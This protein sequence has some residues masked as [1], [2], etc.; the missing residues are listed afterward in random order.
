[1]T[2]P[3]G[4]P[5]V[6]VVKISVV[7]IG[8]NG[9]FVKDDSRQ[10]TTQQ[11][12]GPG[13]QIPRRAL[14]PD[15]EQDGIGKGDQ[16]GD[17][18]RRKHRRGI[19]NYPGEMSSRPPE[20]LLNSFSAYQTRGICRRL[21]YHRHMKRKLLDEMYYLVRICGAGQSILNPRTTVPCTQ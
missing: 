8:F 1:M 16:L 12:E 2:T 11:F 20:K 10:M 17:I 21:V 4:V 18:R 13:C 19:D 15:D 6:I 14:C 7:G 5:A 3:S 9:G